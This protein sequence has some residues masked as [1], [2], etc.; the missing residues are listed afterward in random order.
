MKDRFFIEVACEQR[1]F[2]QERICG[3][4]FLSRKVKEE[5]R[6]IAVLSDGMGHGVKANVLATLTATMA[7]NFTI[8]HKAVEKIA[9]IIM[10]TLP[11]CSVR[12][13][14]YSTFTIVDIE[15]PGAINILEFDNPQSMILRNNRP[16]DPGWKSLILESENNGGKEI[17]S[18][19]FE[20]KKEDRILFCSDG[21]AQSGLGTDRYPLGWGRDRMQEYAVKLIQ[22][23]PKISASELAVKMVNM[24]HQNDD[25]LSKDDTSCA[26]IY[27]RN[28]RQLMIIT[29]PP[30]ET[31]N[32][33]KLGEAVNEFRGKKVVCGATTADIIARELNLEIEDTLVF[34]D[35]ELPP[36]AHMEGIDLVTEGIL[37]LTKAARILNQ[38]TPAVSLGK[39]P[40]DRI[41]KLMQ[42][43]DEIHF[44]IG[45][46]VNIAHQDPNL[47]IDL[48]MRRTVVKRMARLLEEKFLK[49][50][51]IRYI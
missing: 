10:N 22:N 4:V 40:A 48:E 3:D 14:S 31:E 9:E 35:P 29:G 16:F 15:H 49:E 42:Q 28:P 38:Y 47:P 19:R 50:V 6:T 2:G 32:D 39:G 44:L 8:E 12:K 33:R 25:Y 18:C 5:N 51:T 7:V 37:T 36:V 34:E 41:V 24:A 21:I 45:T 11:V 13:M 20:P 30:Y 46:R 27:F 43:S 26:S 1:N 23:N 17:H